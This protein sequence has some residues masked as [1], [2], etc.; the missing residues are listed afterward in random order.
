MTRR[1]IRQAAEGFLAE[2]HPELE[3]PIPIEDILELKLEIEIRPV[4][5]LANAYQRHGVLLSSGKVIV[6]DDDDYM[7]YET[8]CRF[9]LAH[10]LAHI[11][12][13][14]DHLDR[15]SADSTEAAWRAYS[16]LPA[17]ELAEM[18]RDASLFAGQL[19]VPPS[20]LQRAFDELCARFMDTKKVDIRTLGIAARDY[21]AKELAP[22][23]NVSEKVVAIRLEED[24]L[25][26]GG[27][28]G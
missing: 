21:V 22:Q 2:H 27:G 8:R 20:A 26:N 3:V 16:E 28:N 18:E 10:E 6:V 14:K 9:T 1:E 24:E 5:G 25:L 11:I 19:L 4:A 23:F 15:I 17:K 7:N 13:H 12:L